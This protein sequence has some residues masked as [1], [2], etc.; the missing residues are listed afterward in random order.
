ML[1]ISYLR[2]KMGYVK[3]TPDT[4]IEVEIICSL[5]NISCRWLA[6]KFLLS[7]TIVGNF[8]NKKSPISNT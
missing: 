7:N 1:N 5:L 6:G 4:A 3:S 2:T 8:R